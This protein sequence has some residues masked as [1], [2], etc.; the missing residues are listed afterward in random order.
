MTLK[1]LLLFFSL[2]ILSFVNSNFQKVSTYIVT[3]CYSLDKNGKKEE[4]KN[5]TL[6]DVKLEYLVIEYDNLAI[7]RE[8]VDGMKSD[9]TFKL[10]KISNSS[11]RREYL[12]ELKDMIWH[13]KIT[14]NKKSDTFSLGLS[15]NHHT[16]KYKNIIFVGKKV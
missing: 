5:F 11:N 3:S 16:D 14:N 4:T 6:E 7:I 15:I 13:L 2:N 8:K 12:L 9:K 1:F 10:K